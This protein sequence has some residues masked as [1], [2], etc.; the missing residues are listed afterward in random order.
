MGRVETIPPMDRA[1]ETIMGTMD[2]I[3]QVWVSCYIHWQ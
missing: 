1:M 3:K 2:R